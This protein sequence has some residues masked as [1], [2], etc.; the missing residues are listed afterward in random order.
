MKD[1]SKLNLIL[2]KNHTIF[3]KVTIKYHKIL[4]TYLALLLTS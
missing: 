4:T 3:L 1:D 2:Q